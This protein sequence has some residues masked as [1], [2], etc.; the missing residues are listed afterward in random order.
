VSTWARSSEHSG[1]DNFA[2]GNLGWAGHDRVAGS[3]W[4]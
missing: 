3:P 2:N 1:G 4:W